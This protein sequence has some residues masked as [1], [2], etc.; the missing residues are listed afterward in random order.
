MFEKAWEGENLGKTDSQALNMSSRY[1]QGRKPLEK[2]IFPQ[3]WPAVINSTHFMEKVA[4]IILIN[5]SMTATTATNT[6][7]VI[8]HEIDSNLVE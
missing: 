1:E 2:A 3:W 5:K 4:K 8:S 6:M 7:W